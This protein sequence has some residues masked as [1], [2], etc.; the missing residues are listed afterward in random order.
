MIHVI[1]LHGNIYPISS[2]GI[3]TGNDVLSQLSCCYGIANVQ[4]FSQQRP[5]EKTTP[6]NSDILSGSIPIALIHPS[7][8]GPDQSFYLHSG[9]DSGVSVDRF[10]TFYISPTRPDPNLSPISLPQSSSDNSSESDNE[11]AWPPEAPDRAQFLEIGDIAD[12]MDHFPLGMPVFAPLD[13]QF[14][15]SDLETSDTDV[16]TAS[17]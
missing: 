14:R 17:D 5:I 9:E 2:V 4:L 1:D 8:L 11:G 15:L 7:E 12:F 16:D 3:H 13:I 10:S 6:L